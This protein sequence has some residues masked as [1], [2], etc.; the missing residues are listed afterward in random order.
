MNRFGDCEAKKPCAIATMLDPR[1]KALGFRSQKLVD[2]DKMIINE[3]LEVESLHSKED[4]DENDET[5]TMATPTPKGSKLWAMFDSKVSKQ[6]K[7]RNL[8]KSEMEL[9]LKKFKAL[10]NLPRSD[11]PLKWWELSGKALFP[12]LYNTAIKYLIIP[13]TSVP[14]ERVFSKA[15]SVLTKKRNRL[16]PKT[17]NMIITFN[18][19][20]D[21]V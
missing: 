16:G 14:A 20:M 1:F 12:K 8:N 11:D 5:E 2:V 3:V 10:P 17:A 9:E 4:T 6:Q 19:N 21:L 15:G 13:A 18:S 7:N